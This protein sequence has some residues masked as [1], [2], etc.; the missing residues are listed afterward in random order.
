MDY[1]ICEMSHEERMEANLRRLVCMSD[2]QIMESSEAS[3]TSALAAKVLTQ[4]M[5][6]AEA[7]TRV[8]LAR[9]LKVNEGHHDWE[10][11]KAFKNVVYGFD[12]PPGNSLVEYMLEMYELGK[13]ECLD[14]EAKNEW[15]DYLV[16]KDR[17]I[18]MAK[19]MKGMGHKLQVITHGQ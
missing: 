15:F 10:I 14:D 8:R 5:T 13:D 3:L 19:L 16:W 7:A 2:Q 11:V 4:E 1:Y 6:L 18:S 12:F 9:L 17:M